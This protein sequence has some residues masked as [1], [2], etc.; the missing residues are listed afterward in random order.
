MEN[1]GVRLGS[2]PSGHDPVY[3]LSGHICEA[4]APAQVLKDELFVIQAK[5][6]PHRC[7]EIVDMHRILDY[8]IAEL[9]GFSAYSDTLSTK[10]G[11]PV[12]DLKWSNSTTLN[13]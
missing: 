1:A 9:V 12:C 7:M 11:K 3:H 8:V 13:W 5:Q 6:C 4:V 10:L 2:A